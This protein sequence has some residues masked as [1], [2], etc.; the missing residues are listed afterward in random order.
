MTAPAATLRRL[1]GQARGWFSQHPECPEGVSVE[2]DPRE[3]QRWMAD[4][5]HALLDEV[6][7]TQPVDVKR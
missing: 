6:A 5:D 3:V 4:T 1:L 7:E 2:A